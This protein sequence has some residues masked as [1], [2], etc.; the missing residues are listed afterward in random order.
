MFLILV[1]AELAI[2][3]WAEYRVAT[4]WHPHHMTER[5]GLFVIILLGES[6]LAASMAV[7]G[8]VAAR[9]VSGELI[10]ISIAGLVLVFSVW[11][12][13]FLRSAVTRSAVVIVLL[14]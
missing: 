5:Y 9:G 2:P 11:W 7:Q 4:T 1:I 3:V 10:A 14:A 8:A 12:L 13:Y 6:V